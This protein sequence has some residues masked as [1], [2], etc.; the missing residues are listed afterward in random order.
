MF[1]GSIESVG[2]GKIHTLGHSREEGRWGSRE[3][4]SRSWSLFLYSTLQAAESARYIF[5]PKYMHVALLQR[6][7]EVIRLLHLVEPADQKF[8]LGQNFEKLKSI[9][10]GFI[11][12]ITP[13]RVLNHPGNCGICCKTG[14]KTVP[15]A[16]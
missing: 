7:T 11:R 14:P 10:K 6:N 13:R 15:K 1:L 5:L 16:L 8:V 9:F 2:V 4:P 12:L 3:V